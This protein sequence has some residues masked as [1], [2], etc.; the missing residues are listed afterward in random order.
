MSYPARP[1]GLVNSIFVYLFGPI[2]YLLSQTLCLSVSG[3]ICLSLSVCLLSISVHSVS[4]SLYLSLVLSSIVSAYRCVSQSL[5]PL[6]IFSITVHFISPCL[7]L[8]CGSPR[9]TLCSISS[10]QTLLAYTQGWTSLFPGFSGTHRLDMKELLDSTSPGD[11]KKGMIIKLL[12]HGSIFIWPSPL[13]LAGLNKWFPRKHVSV[14]IWAYREIHI[15]AYIPL[16]KSQPYAYTHTYIHTYHTRT[17][18][19][20]CVYIYAHAYSEVCT[21]SHQRQ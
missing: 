13:T 11:K 2:F 6:R 5:V 3:L 18:T 15:R 10:R 7:Y 14:P 19:S 1:E 16:V 20:S 9:L 21:Q 12:I 4:P 8:L 17:H